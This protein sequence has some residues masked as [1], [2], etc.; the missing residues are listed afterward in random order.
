MI[1]DFLEPLPGLT[2][3]F[4]CTVGVLFA[5]Y[6]G[7]LIVVYLGDRPSPA[8]DR[9]LFGWHFLVP[10]RDEEA[11]IGDTIRYLRLTFPYAHV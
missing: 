5:L 7:L 8:G 2:L 10:C 1:R 4:A 9:S 11:V 3:A 6:V